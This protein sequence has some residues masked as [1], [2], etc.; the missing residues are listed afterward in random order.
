V[1]D[2]PGGFLGIV[3]ANVRHLW[4]VTTDAQPDP[5]PNWVLLPPVLVLLAACAVWRRRHDRV[6]LATVAAIAVPIV[7]ALYYFVL[8]RYLIP[9]AALACVLVAVALVELPRRWLA[10]ATLVTLALL[11]TSAVAGLHGASG[12][13]FHPN[14]PSNE[15]KTVGRWIGAHSAPADFTMSTSLVMGYYAQRNIVPIPYASVPR[16]VAFGRHYGVRYLVVDQANAVKFRPQLR[17]LL[18]GRPRPGLVPVHR[19]R[20]ASRRTVVYELVPRPPRFHGTVPLLDHVG[21]GR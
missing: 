13:W 7:T 4:D 15:R 6:V 14:H 5:Y 2:D 20:D 16:I 11:G 10:A 9:S 21:E 19:E 12:G 18:R 17:P 3:G 8:D 1:R